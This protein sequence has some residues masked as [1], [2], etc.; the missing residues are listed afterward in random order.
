MSRINDVA[1]FPHE[2]FPVTFLLLKWR[3]GTHT[4]VTCPDLSKTWQEVAAQR[5]HGGDGMSLILATG[6]W[7]LATTTD[8]SVS[9]VYVLAT[10]QNDSPGGEIFD[11]KKRLIIKK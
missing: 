3:T 11:R 10:L 6:E 4:L 9:G 7:R 1:A 5:W 2:N 8:S